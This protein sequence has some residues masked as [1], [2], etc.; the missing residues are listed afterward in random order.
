MSSV[1]GQT[2]FIE[3]KDIFQNSSE[4][5]MDTF[6]H[7]LAE[8]PRQ[9]LKFI[10]TTPVI[11]G[12]V[13]GL[14]NLREGSRLQ[15]I[16]G[17]EK[18]KTAVNNHTQARSMCD[19]IWTDLILEC[20]P[21]ISSVYS[22]SNKIQ[23]LERAVRWDGRLTLE[24]RKEAFKLIQIVAKTGRKFAQLNAMESL[25]K[26]AHGIGLKD[27]PRLKAIGYSLETLEL[28]LSIKTQALAD[29]ESLTQSESKSFS[30]KL[31]NFPR[32][33]YAHYLLWW[34]GQSPSWRQ[35][36]FFSL[37]KITKLSFEIVFFQVLFKSI[38]K[39][40][41]C[42][43]SQAYRF[44]YGYASWAYSYSSK[45]FTTRIQVFREYNSTESVNDLINE[46]P[47]YHLADFKIL[48]LTSQ[49]LTG[50]ETIR[51]FNAVAQQGAPLQKLFIRSS[52]WTWGD[53]LFSVLTYLEALYIDYSINLTPFFSLNREV[54]SGLTNLKILEISGYFYGLDEQVFSD[55]TQLK[56]IYIGT[57]R[58]IRREIPSERHLKLQRKTFAGLRNLE[59]LNFSQTLV[60]LSYD[61]FFDFRKLKGIV[62]RRL[63]RKFQ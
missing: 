16:G 58:D 5:G 20:L 4:M 48:N 40:I 51:I 1:A 33:F 56:E 10:L 38:L 11:L 39:A 25:A 9:W 43:N 3:L 41:R 47:K 49:G 35:G 45:C 28:I 44:G 13:Q 15:V 50:D 12:T 37:L 23:K 52:N 31:H 2:G 54:F 42:Y 29:L 60:N 59:I 30:G 17:I 18:I 6:V 55:L 36:A 61:F 21:L 34:L 19:I 62:F 63:Y 8:I 53:N 32:Q 22:L 46:I 57:N 14:L 27:L 24:D 26:I 7:S